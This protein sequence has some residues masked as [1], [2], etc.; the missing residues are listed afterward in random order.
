MEKHSDSNVDDGATLF[1]L[2][3]LCFWADFFQG[4]ENVTHS[5]MYRY[6]V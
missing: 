6:N 5:Q 2:F 3:K 4:S 1:E